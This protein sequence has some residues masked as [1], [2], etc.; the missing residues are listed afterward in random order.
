MFEYYALFANYLK[1][2]W[3]KIKQEERRILFSSR[4]KEGKNIVFY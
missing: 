4:E 2:Y 1:V 3:N